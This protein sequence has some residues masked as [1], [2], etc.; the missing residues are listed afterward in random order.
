MHHF[1]N[2]CQERT[3]G[4]RAFNSTASV[5]RIKELLSY[6]TQT[7][8]LTWKEKSGTRWVGCVS[9]S[10]KEDGYRI[11]IVDGK[12]LRAHRIVWAMKYGKWPDSDIDHANG[13]RDDNRI[14]NLR[15]ATLSGNRPNIRG[16]SS[17]NKHGF[18]GVKKNGN[19]WVATI[20]I[21]KKYLYLGSFVTP[22]LAHAEYIKA[23]RRV[24]EFCTI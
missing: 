23:K 11:V 2:H 20:S 15:L 14:E 1:T 17:N 12:R 24:H 4:M 19:R 22:E 10:I 3:N 9:G 5:D 8:A 13:N 16:P 21:N 7:G 18:L 6:D